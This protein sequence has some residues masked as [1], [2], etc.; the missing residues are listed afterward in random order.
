M[1]NYVEMKAQAKKQAAR[2]KSGA[3][4]SEFGPWH[5]FACRFGRAENNEILNVLVAA[6]LHRILTTSLLTEVPGSLT[7][8]Q[9]AGVLQL[10]D[11]VQRVHEPLRNRPVPDLPLQSYVLIVATQ[12]VNRAMCLWFLRFAHNDVRDIEEPIE[13]WRKAEASFDPTTLLRVRATYQSTQND[14]LD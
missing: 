11:R 6:V 1:P 12:S 2:W 3:P 13:L 10:R 14:E 8:E 9:R 4:V 7:P 5:S